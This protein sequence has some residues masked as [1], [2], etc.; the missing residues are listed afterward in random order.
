MVEIQTKTYEQRLQDA[1][2]ADTEEEKTLIA[3]FN[4]V[5]CDALNDRD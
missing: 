5:Y 4:D 1:I 3:G 2:D